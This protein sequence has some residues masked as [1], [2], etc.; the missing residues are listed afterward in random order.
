MR[1]ES[2]PL[3]SA[4][5]EHNVKYEIYRQCIRKYRIGCYVPEFDGSW[6]L[7]KNGF[8]FEWASLFE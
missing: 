8:Y 2:A 5:R 4:K 1:T 6:N 7:K 3:Y